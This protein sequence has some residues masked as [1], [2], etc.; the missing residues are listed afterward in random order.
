MNRSTGTNNPTPLLYRPLST[1]R[2]SYPKYIMLKNATTPI[3]I[4][5]QC[6]GNDVCLILV[7]SGCAVELPPVVDDVADTLYWLQD[8]NSPMHLRCVYNVL[9]KNLLRV[10][11]MDDNHIHPSM[12]HFQLA[13]VACFVLIS[14][15]LGLSNDQ[16]LLP[17]IKGYL[18][19]RWGDQ[20]TLVPFRNIIIDFYDTLTNVSYCYFIFC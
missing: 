16:F 13:V 1:R 7:A 4:K 18:E 3:A 2:C 12:A 8:V 9:A 19:R 17:S 14:T 5:R 15:H 6:L 20:L 10:G 11:I